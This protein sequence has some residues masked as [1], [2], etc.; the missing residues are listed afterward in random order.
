M[1][2]CL[3]VI[4][5]W[6]TLPNHTLPTI[7]C[8]Q[9]LYCVENWPNSNKCFPF[10]VMMI[11]YKRIAPCI[12]VIVR[13]HFCRSWV[14]GSFKEV[15]GETHG[16]C[17]EPTYPHIALYVFKLRPTMKC[18]VESLGFLRRKGWVNSAISKRAKL[19]RRFKQWPQRTEFV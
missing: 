6:S 9:I 14:V 18:Q 10:D 15:A 3:H 17:F 13:D 19:D 1:L 8:H 7:C 5:W 16:S 11:F 4:G 2:A 12:W